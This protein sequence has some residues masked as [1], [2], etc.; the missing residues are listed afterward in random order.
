[1]CS[2]ILVQC[3]K[4]YRTLAF[5]STDYIQYEKQTV[6][7][8]PFQAPDLFASR[9]PTGDEHMDSSERR[10]REMIGC[11]NTPSAA[12][13]TPSPPQPKCKL[14][15]IHAEILPLK[16]AFWCFIVHQIHIRRGLRPGPSWGAYSAP[17]D[18]SWFKGNLLLG[19]IREGTVQVM[20]GSG[21]KGDRKVKE[22]RGRP[23]R[24]SLNLPLQHLVSGKLLPV[25]N[26]IC[27]TSIEKAHTIT[28]D[29]QCWVLNTEKSSLHRHW[30]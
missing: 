1:M 5:Y 15:K 16:F 6:C 28:F 26:K 8:F 29:F 18:P 22:V 21:R 3:K 19:G 17:L 4:I 30:L 7:F 25:L 2:C 14:V 20:A 23:A 12:S 10:E 27:L 11:Q 13:N 24:K 9:R